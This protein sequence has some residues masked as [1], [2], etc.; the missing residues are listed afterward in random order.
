MNIG[1]DLCFPGRAGVPPAVWGVSPK[2]FRPAW[3]APERRGAGQ[4]AR[5]GGR[6]ARPT[7][8]SRTEQN[9]SRF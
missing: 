7:R 8:E 3:G 6:D 2:T 1:D 4:D 5:H 9:R